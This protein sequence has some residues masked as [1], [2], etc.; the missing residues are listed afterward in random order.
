MTS[1]TKTLVLAV[2]ITAV[3]SMG[4][5]L[6]IF[7]ALAPHLM[8]SAPKQPHVP[9]QNPKRTFTT[10]AHRNSVQPASLKKTVTSG[11]PPVTITPGKPVSF[12]DLVKVLGPTVVHIGT[13][14]NLGY[15]P[16]QRWMGGGPRG[17]ASGLGTGVIIQPDGVILTNNHVIASADII[18]VR[19][20]DK[21]EYTAEVIG[22][23][24]ETDLALIRIHAGKPLAYA[25]LGD[26]DRLQI[27]E[28]V[29]AIGNP[30]GLDHTVTAG[31]VSAKGRRN[32][33]PGGK[34][35]YWNFI[36]TDASINPG[37][38]G[39]PLINAMGEVVGINT[40]IDGR[41]A[42]IGFAIPINMVKVVMPHLRKYGQFQRSWIGVSIQPITDQFLTALRLKNKK[43]ALVTEV[44]PGSPGA[45]AGLQPRDV[46]V[47]FGGKPIVQSSDLPWLASTAGIGKQVQ[48]KL[49]RKGKPQNVSVTMAAKP[50]SQVRAP[51]NRHQGRAELGLVVS[52]ITPDVAKLFGLRRMGGVVITMVEAGSYA[53]HAGVVRG[54]I[55]NQVGNTVIRSLADY[56][57]A[58][59]KVPKGQNVMLLLES[60][61]GTRWI[62]LRKR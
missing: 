28:W 41:G 11:R 1:R 62:T 60:Q 58:V 32:I 55:I 20:E 8:P 51:R 52:E 4:G 47:E 14:K 19:L 18:K 50:G 57:G 61:R 23:D 30:F 10:P 48:V 29:V 59:R 6:G 21:R 5:A 44:V 42:G 27:G 22:R 39:G 35:G 31:I 34:R 43:G 7:V 9:P 53:E 36:Q 49:I 17:R 54:E 33:N 45:R 24:P 3:L 46:I 40:A 2:G 38:S 26:S 12:I 15:G 13:V 16:L 56:V 25:K 37:N